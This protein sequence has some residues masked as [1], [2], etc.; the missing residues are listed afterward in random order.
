MN[1]FFFLSGKEQNDEVA[2][3]WLNNDAVRKA[4]HA[5]S[6]GNHCNN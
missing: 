5:E 1:R 2:S 6:V 4:I 3:S